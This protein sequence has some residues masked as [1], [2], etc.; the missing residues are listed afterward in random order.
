MFDKI[1]IAN[2]SEIAIRVIRACQ[3]LGIKTVAVHSTEDEDALH[4]R[5][6]DQSVCIGPAE[7]SRSYLNVPGIISAADVTG[8]SAIHPGYG[9]LSENAGF[10]EVCGACKIKFIG[11][12]PDHISRMGN[13]STARET[14]VA[15]GVPVIPG[16]GGTVGSLE[17]GL[18]I[19]ADIGYPVMLK[20]SAGGGGRGMRQID[21]EDE[22]RSLFDL[23]RNEADSA[24][25]NPDVYIE[26]MI[27]N[28]KHIEIQVMADS[29]GNVI[30]LGDRE[31]SV[32]R[33]H[34]KL[35]EET[36]SVTLKSET[37]GEM[38][39][40][41]INLAK[42][43]GYESVGTIEFLMDGD[44]NYY[45]I[46]M[47]TRIQVE[48]TVTECITGLDLVK[49][50]IRIA[51]GHKLPLIAD[52]VKFYGHSIECRIN[53]E[54]PEKFT[55]SAGT[56]TELNFPGGPGV[57]VDT[58]IYPG[59]RVSPYYDSLIAKLIVHGV[60]REEALAKMKRSLLE[61]HVGGVKTTISLCSKVINSEEFISGKY[62]T[63][64]LPDMIK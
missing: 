8:A 36:P 54:D 7:S 44:G 17:E 47:N 3:E 16:S 11:P 6:A 57:R 24:F 64:S 38:A 23:V 5:F 20:A 40:H 28:P 46:E 62:H 49:E 56:I 43:I 37:R 27:V 22:L 50:Q 18:E 55:P 31:C 35:I 53:A 30:S 13:K 42:N 33:R 63:G 34:Q 39:N 58:A 51:A 29:H 41:A 59:V 26:K 61:F 14:A 9:Y 60:N 19:C 12:S 45:F 2:R 4:V 21:S 10:A 48:H 32:Q 25:G 52:E 1:L 15:C